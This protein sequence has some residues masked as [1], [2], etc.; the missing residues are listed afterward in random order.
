MDYAY[1]RLHSGQML[2][3]TTQ[4]ESKERQKLEE[5]IKS[6]KRLLGLTWNVGCFRGNQGYLNV[7][8]L[9]PTFRNGRADGLTVQES[10][11]ITKTLDFF[12]QPLRAKENK[13]AL[14][15]SSDPSKVDLIDTKKVDNVRKSKN[16]IMRENARPYQKWDPSQHLFDQL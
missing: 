2:E 3:I 16:K 14:N 11:K 6:L 9:S 5:V 4:L 8:I 1:A 7:Y 13:E 15:T 10:E 12:F